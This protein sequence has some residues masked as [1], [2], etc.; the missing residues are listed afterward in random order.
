MAFGSFALNVLNGLNSLTYVSACYSL[1]NLLALS[2][3]LG[4]VSGSTNST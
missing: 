3:N 4:K 2:S 1:K